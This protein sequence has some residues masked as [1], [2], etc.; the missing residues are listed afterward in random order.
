MEKNRLLIALLVISLGSSAQAVPDSMDV[1]ICAPRSQAE[2][3]DFVSNRAEYEEDLFSIEHEISARLVN[4]KGYRDLRFASAL[5]SAQSV[6]PSSSI[7]YFRVMDDTLYLEFDLHRLQD[8]KSKQL[9]ELI[10]PLVSCA[11]YSFP[12]ITEVVFTKHASDAQLTDQDRCLETTDYVKEQQMYH[13]F[14]QTHI[15]VLDTSYNYGEMQSAMF[16]ASD[17]FTLEIDTGGRSYD[18]VQDLICLP[19]EADDPYGGE[20]YP[21]R[22]ESEFLS[23][24]YL[25]YYVD[26]PEKKMMLVARMTYLQREASA[27][28]STVQKDFPNAF[29]LT[30][31]LYQGCMH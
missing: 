13:P 5:L 28:L 15:V 18:P 31:D 26:G 1:W 21:R 12:D 8:Q 17:A 16:Q 29:V 3:A 4:V 24:E 6:A 9:I 30:T 7:T 27:S 23:I 10:E 22:F 25:D 14:I 19:M 2:Y 20:Y 11:V